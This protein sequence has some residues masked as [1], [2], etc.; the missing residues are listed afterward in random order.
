MKVFTVRKQIYDPSLERYVNEEIPTHTIKRARR[1]RTASADTVLASHYISSGTNAVD[2]GTY[3][4]GSV[5]RVSRFMYGANKEI[6]LYVK[7]RT[8]TID[9]LYLPSAGREL[10]LSD[11]YKPVY[12]TEGTFKVCFMGSMTAGTY[13]CSFELI[14]RSQ[15]L[16]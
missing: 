11:S 2:A 15:R 16:R 12:T 13:L 5:A 8:G 9:Y 3:G 4:Y 1:L 7:D 6:E 10:M 14:K